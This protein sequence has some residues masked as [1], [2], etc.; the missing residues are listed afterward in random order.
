MG[1]QSNLYINDEGKLCYSDLY[2]K[3]TLYV[4][5]IFENI[6]GVIFNVSIKK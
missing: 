6:F 5:S 3:E 2:V 1:E 4:E